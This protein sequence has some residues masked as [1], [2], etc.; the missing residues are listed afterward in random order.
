MFDFLK[1]D[2]EKIDTA[3]DINLGEDND[4]AMEMS[5]SDVE[6]ILE[7]LEYTNSYLAQ[8]NMNLSELN[9][10][11]I[12]ANALHIL[13][14]EYNNADSIMDVQEILLKKRALF[15]EIFIDYQVNNEKEN[16]N[17]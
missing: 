11:R 14:S 8:L 16:T 3:E 17:D 5:S 4:I 2:K 6:R 13:D 12:I 15:G 9:K 7:S 10:Q 1:N